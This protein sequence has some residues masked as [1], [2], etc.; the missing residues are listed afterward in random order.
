MNMRVD[1]AAAGFERLFGRKSEVVI[2][3]PGRTEV[4]GNHTDHQRGRVL[5]AA[6][7]LDI[8]CVAAKR[9]D[10][11]IRIRSEGYSQDIVD[12]AELSVR[13]E[14]TGRS[15][16]LIRGVAA[17]FAEH[18]HAIG[19]FDAYTVSDVTGG[20]GLSSSAA[21]ENAV[22]YTLK[23]LYGSGISPVE[24]AKAG[25]Y[26]ENVFF[27][28]P[29]GLMDQMASSVGGFTML[30]FE[31]PS[32]P[33]IE[34]I[35]NPLDGYSLCIVNSGGSHANLTPD[36]AAIP[37]EMRRIAAHFGKE[38]LREVD[39]TEFSREIAALRRYGDRAVL[40]A[41]HFFDENE[42]VLFQAR[43][44]RENH[45]GDFL[46]MVID[47][48]RSSVSC[49]QNIYPVSS[50]DE[51][52]LSLALAVSE[53]LLRGVGAWRVHGGGFAG[54]IL[55]FMPEDYRDRYK[56]GVEAVFGEGC[57]SFL[58]IRHSGGVYTFS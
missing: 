52:G 26:A 20:S 31:N 13:E 34:K 45:V 57:C 1:N 18:G 2:S 58:S 33:V 27:G 16:A 54:T 43:A 35:E 22:G 38:Y 4:G 24:I 48:G 21:F 8:L 46:E 19:G 29:S 55:C 7:N 40:R 39:S 25:Q 50:P 41:M 17:W 51:Q 44:L 12:T 10:G 23:A 14:E 37:D 5:A 15:S 11:V 47:S 56:D 30:D 36:Y 32:E 6:V 42:R 3:A 9:G 49:L 28:K 53:R